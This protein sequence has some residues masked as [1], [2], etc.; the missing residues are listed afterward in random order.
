MKKNNVVTL[1]EQLDNELKEL[2]AVTDTLVLVY[3]HADQ[4]YVSWRMY[5]TG[6]KF[7]FEVGHYMKCDFNKTNTMSALKEF[8]ERII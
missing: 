7:I 5:F 2:I 8:S 1:V 6:E 4:S 3:W